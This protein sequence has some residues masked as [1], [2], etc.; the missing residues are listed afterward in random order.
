MLATG[1]CEIYA[2]LLT[3]IGDFS[4]NLEQD[5]LVDITDRCLS[6]CNCRQVKVVGGGDG[7]IRW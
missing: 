7:V 1:S 3:S 6:H 4:R 5:V 2:H